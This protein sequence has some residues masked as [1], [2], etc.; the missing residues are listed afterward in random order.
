MSSGPN[1]T[2][3]VSL[4][5]TGTQAAVG[6]TGSGS[7]GNQVV[8]MT[9]GATAFTVT[10][11]GSSTL[12]VGTPTLTGT[13]AADYAI[14]GNTCTSGTAP[15]SNCTISVTF[16]PSATGSRTATLNIPSNA[17]S[18]PN[19]V[20]LSGTGIQA[21]A[22]ITGSGSYGNQVVGTTS[23]ASSF[24]VTNSGSSTLTVG[25]PTL[26]GTNAAD[27]AIS[28]NT[29]TSGIA[30][31][32][33]CTISVTFAPGATGSRTATLNIPSNAPSTPNTVSLSGTGLAPPAPAASG[34]GGGA[35]DLALLLQMG[36]L[37]LGRRLKK[38]TPII[39]PG[40]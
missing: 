25:T 22:G 15:S 7:Y 23:G 36:L 3:T 13:N 40:A 28:G 39:K 1:G 38:T 21:A 12:T 11:S 5:G 14:S 20:S 9:S 19:T 27:Y 17:P 37:G 4:S 24:T 18:T 35:L 30:P 6:I 33:N 16:A 32:S 26:T 31:S 2:D 34:G 10:N 8:G 29:C